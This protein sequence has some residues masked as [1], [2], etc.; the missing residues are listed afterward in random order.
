MKEHKRYIEYY[1]IPENRAREKSIRD[2]PENKVKVR[3]I[4]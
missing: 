3:F 4:L 1:S 2:L